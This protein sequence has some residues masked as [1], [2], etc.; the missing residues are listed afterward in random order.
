MV[1]IDYVCIHVSTIQLMRVILVST[2]VFES[3]FILPLISTMQICLWYANSMIYNLHWIRQLQSWKYV[4]INLHCT[5]YAMT[6]WKWWLTSVLEI[7]SAMKSCRR[8]STGAGE[9]VFPGNA[10]VCGIWRKLY[11]RRLE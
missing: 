3:C 8:I 4:D 11:E 7:S 1:Y 9:N 5:H 10:S 2:N 6:T